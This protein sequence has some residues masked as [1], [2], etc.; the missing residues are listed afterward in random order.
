MMMVVGIMNQCRVNQVAIFVRPNTILPRRSVKSTLW[1]SAVLVYR[2]KPAW[3]REIKKLMPL[4]E[5]IQGMSMGKGLISLGGMSKLKR[6]RYDRMMDPST[7]SMSMSQM[8]PRG[9]FRRSESMFIADSKLRIPCI[10]FMFS[11]GNMAG[12]Q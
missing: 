6:R 11:G 9:V 8:M 12:I 2:I 10:V 3:V 7:I 1:P 5:S 4:T